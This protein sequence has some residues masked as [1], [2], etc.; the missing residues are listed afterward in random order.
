MVMVASCA[1]FAAVVGP[2]SDAALRLCDEIDTPDIAL[3]PATVL[4]DQSKAFERLGL[5]WLFRVLRGW[6]MPPWVLRAFEAKAYGLVNGGA[7]RPA[8]SYHAPAQLH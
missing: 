8:G 4:A 6:G 2:V 1:L 7:V 3:C 5:D